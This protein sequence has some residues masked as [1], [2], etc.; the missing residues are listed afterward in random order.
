MSKKIIVVGAS[1]GI[2]KAV[3]V[4][5]LKRGNEVIL[6][7]RRESHL[8]EITAAFSKASFLTIDVT[9]E[10]AVEGSFNA[11]I[12]KLGGLDMIYYAAGVMPTV[13]PEEFDTL[14]DKSMLMVN[15]FGAIAFCNVA[16]RYFLTAKK[17]KIIGISSIAGDRGRRGNPVY[18]ASKAGLNTYLEAL[19]NRLNQHGIQVTTIKPGF[20]KTAMLDGV[21]VP[22]SGLLKAILPEEA[23][24]LILKATDSGKDVAYVPGI[25]RLVGLIIMHIPRFIFKK[26]SI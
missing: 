15:L 26:L 22:E 20:V 11:A 6:M 12:Q 17:G 2:G 8:K 19:R 25:W 16:S 18:N 5:E 1:S 14:K 13:G 21:K 7:A 3:A 10:T 24:R 4:Q 23:A 9:N